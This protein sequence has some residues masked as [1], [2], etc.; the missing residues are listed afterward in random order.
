[1]IRYFLMPQIAPLIW[2]YLYGF[3]LLR[4]AV[5]ISINYFIKPFRKMDCKY[6]TPVSPPQSNWK[7]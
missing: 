1:M 7:L 3:F 2:L 4:L 6:N 5:F